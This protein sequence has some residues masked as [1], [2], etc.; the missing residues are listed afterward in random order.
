M[1]NNQVANDKIENDD[2]VA[3]KLSQNKKPRTDDKHF[4]QDNLLNN[5]RKRKEEQDHYKSV[6]TTKKG[7][8]G[9]KA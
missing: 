5:L 6:Q 4:C 9:K 3:A 1:E 7:K 2:T 8:T